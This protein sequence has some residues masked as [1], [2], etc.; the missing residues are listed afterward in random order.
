MPV[1][2]PLRLKPQVLKRHDSDANFVLILFMKTGTSIVMKP[3]LVASLFEIY[4]CFLSRLQCTISANR[5]VP[6]EMD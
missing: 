4:F 5:S 3:A 2:R 6:G 1:G